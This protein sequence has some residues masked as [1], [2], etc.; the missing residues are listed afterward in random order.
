MGKTKVRTYEYNGEQLTIMQIIKASGAN[1]SY[2]ALYRRI[3][4]TGMSVEEA[5]NRPTL[6]QYESMATDE[7]YNLG[8][9]PRDYNLDKI[10]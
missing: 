9:K 10:K 2:D 1:I 7:W 3:N 8:N 4:T 5:V 6:P